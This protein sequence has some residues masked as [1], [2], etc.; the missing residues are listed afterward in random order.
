M[1]RSSDYELNDPLIKALSGSN[2]RVSIREYEEDDD[3]PRPEPMIIEDPRVVDIVRPPRFVLYAFIEKIEIERGRDTVRLHHLMMDCMS[4]AWFNSF[5]GVLA[6]VPP[7]DNLPQ[8]ALACMVEATVTTGEL[9]HIRNTIN[10]P[11]IQEEWWIEIEL[12]LDPGN[13]I[14]PP[15]AVYWMEGHD[16][17]TIGNRPNTTLW[18]WCLASRVRPTGRLI[19]LQAF[20]H[21]PVLDI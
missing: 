8:E 18:Y 11:H 14:L 3:E 6:A 17:A 1:K 19:A 12:I 16:A 20:S 15:V 9:D 7:M 2:R 13:R 10:V 21:R 4:A 5:N